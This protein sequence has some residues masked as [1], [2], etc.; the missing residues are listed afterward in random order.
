[1]V[2]TERRDAR[3]EGNRVT[4]F[5]PQLPAPSPGVRPGEAQI[6]VERLPPSRFEA[7]PSR[8]PTP[9]EILAEVAAQ[10]KRDGILLVGHQ[11]H[12]GILLGH[13]LAGGRGLEIP[14]KKASLARVE[15]AGRGRGQLRALLPAP[16]LE[17]IARSRG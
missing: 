15:L 14:L 2:E 12:L 9:E 4:A 17:Q 6:A 7:V 11:P 5:R 10:E 8:A 3:I 16:V 1:M 13:L